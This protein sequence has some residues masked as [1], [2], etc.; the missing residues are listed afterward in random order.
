MAASL[1]ANLAAIVLKADGSYWAKLGFINRTP[2]II[3]RIPGSPRNIYYRWPGEEMPPS[4]YLPGDHRGEWEVKLPPG[5]RLTYVLD[6]TATATC[7]AVDIALTVAAVEDLGDGLFRV[8]FRATNGHNQTIRTE[9]P[10][11]NDVSF[12]EGQP[13]SFPAAASV[14][15]V[16]DAPA[17][18]TITWTLGA[19][20]CTATV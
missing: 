15:W 11:A 8:T 13:T 6:N 1:V 2:E 10:A 4:S 19:D 12:G 18:T 5:S 3:N 14:D 9:D 20:H 16:V 17:G 7:P